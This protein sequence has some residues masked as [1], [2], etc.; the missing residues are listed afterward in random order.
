MEQMEGILVH[1]MGI[2]HLMF[3]NV[4]RR[5][6]DETLKFFVTTLEPEDIWKTYLDHQPTYEKR[7][8]YPQ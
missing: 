3:F 5:H 2:Y 7:G 6:S 8:Y 4:V 1:G